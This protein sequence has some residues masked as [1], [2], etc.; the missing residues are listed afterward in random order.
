MGPTG[1]TP[2]PALRRE[3]ERQS[4]QNRPHLTEPERA[5]GTG[6]VKRTEKGIWN[7]A[8]LGLLKSSGMQEE[9]WLEK[10]RVL[11]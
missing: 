2:C 11:E 10:R 8:Y 1:R 7:Q 5:K 6:Q 3:R 4:V 9:M